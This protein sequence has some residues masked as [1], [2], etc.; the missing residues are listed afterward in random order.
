M[1]AVE[2]TTVKA[3]GLPVPHPTRLPLPA[4]GSIRPSRN[5]LLHLGCL[6]VSSQFATSPSQASPIATIY[7]VS[8]F[9]RGRMLMFARLFCSLGSCN[10]RGE[11]DARASPHRGGHCH[12]TSAATAPVGP[13]ACS[14]RLCSLLGRRLREPP[15]CW[16]QATCSSIWATATATAAILRHHWQWHCP[17]HHFGM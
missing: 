1:V 8:T 5:K 6:C 14:P 13:R 7:F 12:G 17:W 3:A 2:A 15:R 10:G 16:H 11:R 4:E 9:A